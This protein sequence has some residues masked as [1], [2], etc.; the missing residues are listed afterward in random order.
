[1]FR[2]AALLSRQRAFSLLHHPAISVDSELSIKRCGL[3]LIF[4]AF[5]ICMAIQHIG[6]MPSG[7]KRV[8]LPMYTH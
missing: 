7:A 6:V 8:I 3:Q 5:L 1:M 2:S 4:H